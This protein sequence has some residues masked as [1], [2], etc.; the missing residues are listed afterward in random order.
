MCRLAGEIADGVLFNWLTPEH[1]SRSADWVAAGA[2]AAG[3]PRP[4]LFAYVRVALGP[5]AGARLAVEGARYAAI[6]AYGDHFARMGVAPVATAIAAADPDAI[7]PALA[8]WRDVV[9]EVVLR[10]L[11]AHD[12]LDEHLAILRAAR[13]A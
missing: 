2:A 6:P 13:P 7:P 8:P 9:D 3:R 1:A 10:A 12:T 5:D 4:T 11:T